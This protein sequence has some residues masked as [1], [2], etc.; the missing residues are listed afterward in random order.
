MRKAYR[1]GEWKNVGEL[2]HKIKPSLTFMGMNKTIELL[3]A[4]RDAAR[5]E[6]EAAATH[7]IDKLEHEISRAIQD[8][9]SNIDQQGQQ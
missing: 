8:L 9:K 4:L 5:T 7:L 3:N 2:A 6:D 1:A